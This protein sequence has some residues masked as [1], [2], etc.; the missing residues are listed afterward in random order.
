MERTTNWA[1]LVRSFR[2][3]QRLTQDEAAQ[4]LGVSQPTLSRW[5]SGRQVPDSRTRRRLRQLMETLMGTQRRLLEAVV[6]R[7]PVPQVLVDHRLRVLRAS[8]PFARLLDRQPEELHGEHAPAQ[9]PLGADCRDTLSRLEREG[10]R[11]GGVAFAECYT[12][13][14]DRRG[15]PLAVRQL[16]VPAEAGEDGCLLRVEVGRVDEA[17]VRA[18]LEVGPRVRVT[19]LP[20]LVDIPEW[21]PEGSEEARRSPSDPTGA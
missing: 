13:L 14:H 2:R 16:W 20:E 7:S 8:E 11:R 3:A 19:L 17:G 5:E 6:A 1:T 15:R 21:P 10:L 9:H 18:A 4:L 12:T